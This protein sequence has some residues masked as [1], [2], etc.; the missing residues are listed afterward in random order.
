MKIVNIVGARPNFI[1]IAPLLSEMKK[2]NSF[3]TVLLHTG[4]HYDYAMSERFFKELEIPEPDFH[5]NV[6]SSSHGKQVANIMRH[7][8]DYCENEN[9]DLVMVVGDVNS[10]V[11]CSLVAAKRGIKVGH[12]EAGIR[13]RDRRMP[14]EINRIITDS[15]TDFFFPPTEE[16]VANLL[17]EGHDS[18]NIHLVGNIMIDTLRQQQDAIDAS[19]IIEKSGLKANEYALLTLHRPSNVDNAEN[20]KEIVDALLAI[21]SK[22]KIV[23]PVHPRTKKQLIKFGL[24]DMLEDHPGILILNPLGYH[25]FGKLVKNARFVLTDSGGIQEETTIYKIPCLTL[26]ENTERMV[27]VDIGTNELLGSNGNKIIECS[28]KILNGD[29]KKGDIPQLWDGKTA[30]RIVGFLQKIKR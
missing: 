5:L 22:I 1:K 13:S 11:A 14:E 12:V 23:F 28:N 20:L 30:S 16:A 8:D 9:P 7:F 4:Q 2:V 21:Q 10:T 26:R 24:Y 6:G 19:D 3:E 18:S 25:A 29:W 17:K 15:V 27:T